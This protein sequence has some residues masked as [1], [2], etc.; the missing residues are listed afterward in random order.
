L[1]QIFTGSR[2]QDFADSRFQIFIGS[3][4]RGFTGSRFQIY[5]D[6]TTLKTYFMNFGKPDVSR[7]AGFS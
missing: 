1:F 4:L 3:R 2:L 5:I 6:S 7:V